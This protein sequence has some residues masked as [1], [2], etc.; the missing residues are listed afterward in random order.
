MDKRDLR[1]VDTDTLR[2]ATMQAAH[3][4]MDLADVREYGFGPL[5]CTDPYCDVYGCYCPA[6]TE[7][8]WTEK[9]IAWFESEKNR[10]ERWIAL[11]DEVLAEREEQAKSIAERTRGYD[12]ERHDP[13]SV[14]YD[15]TYTGPSELAL[16]GGC[17]RCN[18]DDCMCYE[19]WQSKR[20]WQREMDALHHDHRNGCHY[21]IM[22]HYRHEDP[23]RQ[24]DYLELTA[25]YGKA[26]VANVLEWH[27]I[28]YEDTFDRI[29][30]TRKCLYRGQ[31]IDVV[32]YTLKFKPSI[33]QFT[34]EAA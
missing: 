15:G 17:D 8:T 31:W 5:G 4:L 34:Q 24:T 20:E 13:D 11:A 2:F 32:R 16:S 12:P 21:E 1:Y 7:K 6:P 28:K 25:K 3:Q 14:F 10:I 33:E 23:D 29:H 26:R 18:C 22:L 30:I 27:K 9:Q 19:N